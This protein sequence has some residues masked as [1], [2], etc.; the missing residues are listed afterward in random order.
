MSALIEQ[1]TQLLTLKLEKSIRDEINFFDKPLSL[2]ALTASILGVLISMNSELKQK[3]LN[4]ISFDIDDPTALKGFL[5]TNPQTNNIL[6]NSNQTLNDDIVSD[7]IL[8]CESLSG[9]RKKKYVPIEYYEKTAEQIADILDSSEKNIDY[10][11]TKIPDHISNISKYSQFGLMLYFIIQLII[12]LITSTDHPSTFRLKY[13]QKLIRNSLDSI[14]SFGI[15][16]FKKIKV[17]FDGVDE[18]LITIGAA[19][20]LY[21]YNKKISQEYSTNVLR[22]GACDNIKDSIISSEEEL[23]GEIEEIE[24]EPAPFELILSCPPK[25]EEELLVPKEPYEE[26]LE[27]FAC[28]LGEEDEEEESSLESKLIPNIATKAIIE[29]LKSEEMIPL[30][31]KDSYV[32][33]RTIIAKIGETFVYSPINGYIDS[34]ES[35]NNITLRN[36]SDPTDGYLATNIQLLNEKYQELSEIKMFL[37]DWE[38]ISL[39]PI[40]MANSPITDGSTAAEEVVGIHYN[41][42]GKRFNVIRDNWKTLKED[43]ENNIQEITGEDNVKTKAENENLLAIKEE[44]EEE[45]S[46]IYDYLREVEER[47]KGIARITLPIL[48]EFEMAEYFA[49]NLTLELNTIKDPD[50]ITKAYR[51]QINIFTAQRYVIDGWKPLQIRD[52]GNDLL[53]ELEKGI[54]TGDWF[55]KGLNEYRQR[56][57]LSDIEDW[58]KEIAEENEKLEDFEKEELIAKLMFLFEFYLNIQETV[59]KYKDLEESS[60]KTQVIKEGN[61]ISNYFGKLWIRFK[62]LPE[63]IEEIEKIIEDLSLISKYFIIEKDFEQYRTYTITEEE[64]ECDS[65]F[66]E[67]NKTET[68]LGS[69]RYWLKYCA[70]ATLASVINPITGWSTGLILPSGPLLLPTV[71]IPIKPIETNYGFIVLGLTITGVYVF[72]LALFV[73]YSTNYALPIADPIQFIKD[74]VENL[75][76][77][78]SADLKTFKKETLKAYLDRIKDDVNDIIQEI[79]SIKDNINAHKENRPAKT[80]KTVGE[81]SQWTVEKQKLKTEERKLKTKQWKLEKK[82]QIV[83]FAYTSGTKITGGTDPADAALVVLEQTEEFLNSQ[84]DAL[85]DLIEQGERII[86]PL[87]ITLQPQEATFSATIKKPPTPNFFIKIEDKLND[88]VNEGPLDELLNRFKLNNEDFM[89]NGAKFNMGGF[90]VAQALARPL[91]IKK[92]PFP[93]YEN[94]NPLNLHWMAFLNLKFV[95]TGAKTYG[96]PGQMPI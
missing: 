83:E 22:E 60:K 13:I 85:I 76:E 93:A 51:E 72:P 15:D 49:L 58:L 69:I 43:Y 4:H 47:A 77:T 48:G 73:N 34:L 17:V 90:K 9:K 8:R 57:V 94:L 66:L 28:D 87:P 52:K 56:R 61:Y 82:Y 37:K 10:F 80:I 67:E 20:A 30:V 33:D 65:T 35:N 16:E 53:D 1:I 62:K 75:K 96:I 27:N 3:L 24:E 7:L 68:N 89:K 95:P 36:I 25:P 21:L 79:D 12:D 40:M 11:K 19:S 92:D 50:N 64:S 71:Y 18:L 29:N 86:A 45:E 31:G 39:Y 2:K 91:I 6:K 44:L 70:F 23:P 59:T 54:T 84:L 41:G 14:K 55:E 46:I 5:K 32:T 63:E 26:K 38:V 78:I 74:Q 88:T 42:M 81:Y